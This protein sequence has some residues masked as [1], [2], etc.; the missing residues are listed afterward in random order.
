[1]IQ[2]AAATHSFPPAARGN[3]DSACARLSWLPNALKPYR[4]LF[5][6][7]ADGSC[8]SFQFWKSAERFC[9]TN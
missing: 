7:G 1:L 3:S 8:S 9:A 4:R 2:P 5:V 6:L